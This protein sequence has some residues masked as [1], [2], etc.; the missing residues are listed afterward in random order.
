[1]LPD[2]LYNIEFKSPNG[3][4]GPT[5]LLRYVNADENAPEDWRLMNLI[6]APDLQWF[7]WYCNPVLLRI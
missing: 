5:L 6:V 3:A 1:M 2:F 4:E 7:D